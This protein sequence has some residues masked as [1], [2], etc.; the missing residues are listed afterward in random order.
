MKLRLALGIG[1]IAL[2]SHVRAEDA[3]PVKTPSTYLADLQTK[4]DHVARRANQPAATGSSVAG[5][6]G[7]KQEPISKQLYWKGKT[8]EN[9]VS[10]EEVKLFRTGVE[11]ARAG[12]MDV[13]T[14]T[15]KSFLEKYPKSSLKP[16]VEETLKVL[17]SPAQ[18]S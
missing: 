18:A 13:A 1:L 12:K 6:R 15:L 10:I 9:P 4:L 7:S 2:A 8:T 5:L 17:A 11:E 3:Q 16:D 14:S